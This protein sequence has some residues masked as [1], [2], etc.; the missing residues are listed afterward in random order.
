MAT[1]KSLGVDYN[2][3]GEDLNTFIKENLFIFTNSG[4]QMILPINIEVK[5]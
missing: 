3:Y 2:I 4:I 1:A 5:L